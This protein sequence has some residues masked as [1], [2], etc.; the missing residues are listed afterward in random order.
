[1]NTAYGP[2]CGIAFNAKKRN[3]EE[4]PI[5]G[6]G[7]EIIKYSTNDFLLEEKLKKSDDIFVNLSSNEINSLKARF[8]N[9]LKKE[10]EKIEMS[11]TFTSFI[12]ENGVNIPESNI[13]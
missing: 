7:E 2:H 13:K 1:M 3:A 9:N 6:K 12:K 11:E 4:C 8:I 10:V 5:C